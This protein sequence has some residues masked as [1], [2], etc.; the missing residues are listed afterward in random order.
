MSAT[1]IKKVLGI[2]QR[3]YSL[4]N[5]TV[6]GVKQFVV[7]ELA[8]SYSA[9]ATFPGT[10]CLHSAFPETV[11]TQHFLRHPVFTAFP[12]TPCLQ[13]AFPD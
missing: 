6:G 3:Y 10:P 1:G 9:G 5:E 8:V 2:L 4:V 7:E 13:S 11:Y 12:E